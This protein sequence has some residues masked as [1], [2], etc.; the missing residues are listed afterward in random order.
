[1]IDAFDH[2]G[3]Y[4]SSMSENPARTSQKRWFAQSFR[5]ADA[6]GDDLSAST[7]AAERFEMVEILTAR[8]MELTGNVAPTY[9]RNTIPVRLVRRGE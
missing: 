4:L 9:S 1:M 3:T 8:M 7:T 6:P 2:S 5:L